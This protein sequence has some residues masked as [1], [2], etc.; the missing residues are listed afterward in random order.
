MNGAALAILPR[1]TAMWFVLHRAFVSLVVLAAVPAFMLRPTGV[2][3]DSVFWVVAKS[4][5]AGKILYR[6]VFF[7]QPPLFIFI[8][9]ALWL[10]TSN[11]FFHRVF[12]VVAWILNGYLFYLALYRVERNLRSLAAGLFLVSAFVLQSYA[13]HTEIF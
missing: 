1:A 3:D 5:D 11:I 9:Q 10:L 6:E 4:L 2:M 12:L 8:P 7:T 13:L